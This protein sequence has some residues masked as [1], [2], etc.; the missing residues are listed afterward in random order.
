MLSVIGVVVV[1]SVVILVHELG[2]FLMARYIGVKVERFALGLG[3]VLLSKRIGDTEYVICLIPFG[4][5]VKMAG[6]EPIDKPSSNRQEFFGQ[7]PGRRFWIIFAG[8]AVNYIFAFLIF[9]FIVPTSRI[10]VVIKD[11]PAYKSGIETGDRI[12]AIN[13]NEVKYWYQVL[14][15]VSKDYNAKPLKMIIDREGVTSEVTITP[16]I[17]ELKGLFGREIKKPKI[18]IS[19]FGD[20]EVLKGSPVKHLTV[21]ARQI[22]ANTVLTYKFIWYLVTGKIA[23]K[24]AAAGPVGIAVILGKAIKIGFVYLVYLVAHIN[25]ALAIFNLLPFPIL[26]GGHIFFLGIE[27]I[28]KRPL[29][30]KV[31]EI[32]QYVAV[33]LIIAF[34]LLVTWNDISLWILKR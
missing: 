13:D 31:Q 34:F 11:M 14:D 5:Y 6:D 26:D 12:V 10:G 25:L 28:R 23:L 22:F 19:Y 20:V 29:S 16:D 3:K 8:A 1:F 18:G 2:H 15:F 24:G 33:T 9:S 27:K 21:G 7:P 17:L 32:V 4:G 30:I